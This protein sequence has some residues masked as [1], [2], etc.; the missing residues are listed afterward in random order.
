MDTALGAARAARPDHFGQQVWPPCGR[1]TLGLYDPPAADT[2]ALGGYSR[3][4]AAEDQLFLY[5]ALFPV[6]GARRG[7]RGRPGGRAFTS[8][9]YAPCPC[10]LYRMAVAVR[11]VSV[12]CI[13][14]P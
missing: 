13:S 2:D 10:S 7:G 1:R 11:P 4:L 8:S 14:P 5:P 12:R 6:L 3:P 9:P